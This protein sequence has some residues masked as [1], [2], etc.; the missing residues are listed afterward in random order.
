MVA[1][2][3][4]IVKYEFSKRIHHSGGGSKLYG[5]RWSGSGLD[6]SS[7]TQDSW[8][9]RWSASSWGG[10]WSGNRLDGSSWTQDSWGGRWSG[11]RLGGSRWSCSRWSGS[12][13]GGSRSPGRDL[14]H[15]PG[16]SRWSH[17]RS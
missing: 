1:G 11:S 4:L 13:L 10:R 17:N 9:G 14:G 16:Q 12:R 5:S 6:G 2:S 8:G 7:W 3:W 15:S